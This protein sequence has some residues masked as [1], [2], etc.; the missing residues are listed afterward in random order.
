MASGKQS[1]IKRYIDII[2]SDTS[3]NAVDKDRSI[4]LSCLKYLTDEKYRNN[5]KQIPIF[6]KNGRLFVITTPKDKLYLTNTSN[7]LKGFNGKI[8]IFRDTENK[9]V[10]VT[11]NLRYISNNLIFWDIISK[12]VDNQ[13]VCNQIVDF[14]SIDPNYDES[15]SLINYTFNQYNIDLLKKIDVVYK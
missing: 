2:I 8:F 4:A 10:I 7:S 6:S 14:E 15:Y 1:N 12:F 13:Y 9:K 3:R 11:D 5:S